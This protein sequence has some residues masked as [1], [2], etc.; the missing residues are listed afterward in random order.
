ADGNVL[1]DATGLGINKAGFVIHGCVHRARL[2]VNFVLHTHTRAGVAVS[3]QRHGLLPL[4][5]HASRVRSLLAYHDYEGIALNMDEQA[6]LA[7]DLGPSARA[8]ILRNHGLLA[9][10]RN[11]AEAFDVMYYLDAA[12]QMQ[13]DALSAGRAE[14]LEIPDPVDAVAASQF[15]RPDGTRM[16]LTWD[17][18][19]RELDAD[20]APYRR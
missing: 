1:H 2:E 16:Q 8:M 12:C 9:L 5:Q 7:K 6:R 18:W 15:D 11:A 10:G 17:A 4:T 20:G 19:L 13:V 14:V 3:A